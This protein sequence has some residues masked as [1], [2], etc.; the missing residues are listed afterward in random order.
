MRARSRFLSLAPVV[1]LVVALA[2][3]QTPLGTAFTY[4]AG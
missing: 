2:H 3:A 1:L 4:Q